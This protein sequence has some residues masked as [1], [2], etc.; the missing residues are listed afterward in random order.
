[1]DETTQTTRPHLS[2][3]DLP[4]E[5]LID[6]FNCQDFKLPVHDP[7][8]YWSPRITEVR[9]RL[10]YLGNIRLVCRT[11]NRLVSPF[12]CPVVSVSL[13]SESIDRLE[14]LSRNPL[15][16][17]GIRGI[18]ISL[19]F[20]PRPIA[21]DFEKYRHYA[22]STI[23]TL[24]DICDW[25]TDFHKYDEDDVSEDAFV[26]RSFNEAWNTISCME[27]EDELRIC[28]D[29]Y[30]AAHADQ[31]RI[32][33]NGSFIRGAVTALS[34][35]TSSPFIWFDDKDLQEDNDRDV[36]TIARNEDALLHILTR[37]HEWLDI[38]S[39]ICKD[40]DDT[41]LFFP[42]IIF[43]GLPIA[44]YSADICLKYISINCFPLQK[45]YSC[46]A[47]KA[48]STNSSIDSHY[49]AL[50]AS[51]CQT[52]ETFTFGKRGMSR[53]SLRPERQ[54]ASDL[55]IIDN[56][57]G[58]A[59]SGRQLQ[60]LHVSLHPFKVRYRG[61]DERRHKE[62]FYPAS[63]IVTAIRSRQLRNINFVYVDISEHDLFSLIESIAPKHLESFHI[64]GVV[65]S[66]GCYAPAM[67]LLHSTVS[68]KRGV[69]G[70][71][72]TISFNGLQGA[73]FHRLQEHLH[74]ELLKQVK[75]W[76]MEGAAG[77]PNPLLNVGTN[78]AK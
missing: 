72:P 6:I 56:F 44:C 10:K 47:P 66:N 71:V 13:C 36:I 77:A 7:S 42:A 35:C 63:S 29:K 2:I 65:L 58:A 9:S 24:E 51:A 54:S 74:P 19:R 27:A 45:G 49:W 75:Q 33:S 69:S 57:F 52:L 4:R 25:C 38:E 22:L 68:M 30:A 17:Q 31:V 12:L 50:F 21:S 39:T 61:P 46:L 20:R 43:T 34:R 37:G 55:A 15:I 59:I 5:I 8:D 70:L 16:A 41:D 3:L 18:R 40:D 28:F 62:D 14:G 64:A 48:T 53:P 60:R 73:E 67:G 26:W 76:I 32:V 23:E 78:K 11:L 1:M